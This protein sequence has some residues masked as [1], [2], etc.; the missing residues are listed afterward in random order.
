M[1]N[2]T[3]T[4]DVVA[5]IALPI[6]ENQLG[7]AKTVHRGFEDEFA[8]TV[9]GYKKGDTVSIRRPV[10]FT[11]RTGAV[12]DLQD[13]IEGKTNVVVN[14][15]KG[16]DFK[17]TSADMTLKVEDLAERVIKPAMST[18]ANE[19]ERDLLTTMYKGFYHWVG[20]PGE[21]INS[22][23]DF[24]K[25]PLRADQILM[26]QEGRT[27]VLSPADQWGMLGAQTALFIQNAA[28]GAYRD[29]DLG[30][31]AGVRTMMSQVV[32]T[33][34]NGDAVDDTAVMDGDESVNVTTYDA[35]KDTWTQTIV[36]DGWGNSQTIKAGSVFTI[37]DCYMVNPKTKVRT[38]VLQEF[39]VVS[40]APTHAAGG[41][42]QITISPPI[43]TS[44]PHQTVELTSAINDNAITLYGAVSTGYL[45]NMLYHK[46]STALVMVP[47]EAPQGVSDVGRQSKN[48]FSVRVVPGYDFINDISRWRLD[49]L[50]GIKVIDPRQGI[51]MSGTSA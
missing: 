44:G 6:L 17:F 24:S 35:V 9:N 33:H 18:L 7:V 32:P 50:Y 41:D 34:T 15:Q 25:G 16:V 31:I 30:K 29:G 28:N 26:P 13:V 3:L 49:V 48:G 14:T 10:D 45:Q 42:T 22:F 40:D 36:T 19:I 47:M 51:R 20:T 46:N 1:A 8:G 27:S 23:S 39:V 11:V 4:A 5:K 12:V 43:I 21:T 38:T 2:R 37:A